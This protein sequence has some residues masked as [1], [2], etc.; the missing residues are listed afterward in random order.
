MVITVKNTVNA[1]VEKVW[2]CWTGPEHIKKW[3]NASEDWHTPQASNDLQVGGRFNVRMEAKDGSS[4]FD[5]EGIYDKVVVNE[6]IEYKI[7]DCRKVVITF[8]DKGDGTEVVESFD[9]ETENTLE[10]Q[11]QGWQSILDNF[12]RYVE[13]L[14]KFEKLSFEIRIN[15]STEKVFSFMLDETHY[16]EWTSVFNPSSNYKGNWKKDTKMLFFGTTEEGKTEGMVSRITENIPNRLICIEHYGM[17][18]DEKEIISGPSVDSWTGS[19]EK[20]FFNED[21]GNTI[22]TVELDSVPEYKSY[23]DETYPK[24][25]EKLKAICEE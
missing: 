9:A 15:A 2:N 18:T 6:C 25:L 17:I 5:F 13:A 22:L 20:Y 4:G 3:N 24:A 7:A 11:R 14:G 23:F 12:K 1:P 10:L 21:N 19:T 16:R 8:K